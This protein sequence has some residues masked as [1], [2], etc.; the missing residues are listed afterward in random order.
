[1]ITGLDV[2]IGEVNDEDACLRNKV[3]LPSTF[4]KA[5]RPLPGLNVAGVDADRL[6][7]G[8]AIGNGS[9]RCGTD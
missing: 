8:C 1:M 9:G 6:M 4:P 5:L 7:N 2:D 3:L